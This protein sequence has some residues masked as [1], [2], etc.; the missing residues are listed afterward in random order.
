MYE[1]RIYN[2]S[3]DENG[4][5][6]YRQDFNTDPLAY[7]ENHETEGRRG[8]NENHYAS[9]LLRFWDGLQEKHPGMLMD[10]CA[11]GGRRNDVDVM[12]R[13]V[14]LIRSDRLFVPDE[15]QAQFVP[16]RSPISQMLT[17]PQATASPCI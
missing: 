12:K 4:V 5:D 16:C 14:P 17:M 8:A 13:M 11:S 9:G 3:I 6:F 7:I 1:G 2:R 10:A 15:Q